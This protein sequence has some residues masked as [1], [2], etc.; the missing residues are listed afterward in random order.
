MFGSA[1]MFRIQSSMNSSSVLVNYPA[2]VAMQVFTQ[3]EPVYICVIAALWLNKIALSFYGAK[4]RPHLI[5]P[6]FVKND[7]KF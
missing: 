4:V 2:T 1:S 5:N 6:G 7:K 3:D